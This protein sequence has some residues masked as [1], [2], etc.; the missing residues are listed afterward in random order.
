MSGPQLGPELGP[1]TVTASDAPDPAMPES[2]GADSAADVALSSEP[3]AIA[4]PLSAVQNSSEAARQVKPAPKRSAVPLVIAGVVAAALG[5]AA[6]Y[7]GQQSQSA[8][9]TIRTKHW[10]EPP[11]PSH[12]HQGHRTELL[13]LGATYGPHPQPQH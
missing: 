10:S 11:A 2:G 8:T 9:L 3:V 13:M 1:D 4:A 6:A 5:Y 7:W 12:P